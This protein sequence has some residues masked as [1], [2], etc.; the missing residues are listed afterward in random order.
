MTAAVRS[1]MTP[2]ALLQPQRART[3]LPPSRGA[4]A[5]EEMAPKARVAKTAIDLEKSILVRTVKIW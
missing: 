5:T 4:A 1:V 3:L 2:A